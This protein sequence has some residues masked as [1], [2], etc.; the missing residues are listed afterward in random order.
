MNAEIRRPVAAMYSY[1]QYSTVLVIQNTNWNTNNCH[2]VL[3]PFP[4]LFLVYF[5][6]GTFWELLDCY[7]LPCPFSANS[8]VLCVLWTLLNKECLRTETWFI[9]AVVG[10]S[11]PRKTVQFGQTMDPAHISYEL[12]GT[13]K[14]MR[15][16]FIGT[17]WGSP[18][19]VWQ[20]SFH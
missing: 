4:T 19:S 18:L 2:S 12:K 17:Q 8:G 9:C 13:S 11:C 3:C 6:R 16:F 10:S 20:V 5:T 15:W 7:L 1:V 14:G